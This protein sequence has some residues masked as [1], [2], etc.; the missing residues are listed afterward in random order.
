MRER[1]WWYDEITF[2]IERGIDP[3]KARIFTILRWMWHGDF[4]PLAAAIVERQIPEEALTLLHDMIIEGRL[5][6]VHGKR[7]RPK[8]PE[9][10]AR[11]IALALLYEEAQHPS[12]ETFDKIAEAFG[13]SEQTV[14]QAVTRLRKARRKTHN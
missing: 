2:Y 5:K 11:N 4:R 3:E 10:Q 8:S 13:V 6:L 9:A 14:R 1:N 7:Q 12:A